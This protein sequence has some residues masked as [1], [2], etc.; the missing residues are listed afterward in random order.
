MNFLA[1]PLTRTQIPALNDLVGA[2]ATPR[3]ASAPASASRKE[4]KP[5]PSVESLQP[6]AIPSASRPRSRKPV[7]QPSSSVRRPSSTA[8]GSLTK[9]TLPA[10]IR[11]YFLPQNY[12]L[13]EAFQ[14]AKRAM[15]SQ[16]MIQGVVYRPSLL[17]AA[18]VQIA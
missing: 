2:G 16:A 9:P 6:V 13:P 11:E 1:G 4:S 18:Q 17:A 14:S 5:K 3:A 10:G 7:A 15:P 8:D 12:S